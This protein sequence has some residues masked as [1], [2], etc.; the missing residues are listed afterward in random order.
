MARQEGWTRQQVI[1][2]E[3]DPSHYQIED[4]SSNRSHLY[5]AP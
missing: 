5:E 3:N 1:E 2:Y 4:P